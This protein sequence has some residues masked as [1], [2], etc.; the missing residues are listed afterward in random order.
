MHAGSGRGDEPPLVQEPIRMQ[1]PGRDGD[2]MVEAALLDDAGQ[3]G[4]P[5]TVTGGW[6]L[7]GDQSRAVSR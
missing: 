6:R 3:Q 4:V 2:L 5:A 7:V 1:R